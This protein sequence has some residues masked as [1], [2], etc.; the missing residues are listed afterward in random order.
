MSGSS[1]SRLWPFSCR[2]GKSANGEG[3]RI[4]ADVQRSTGTGERS[5][6]NTETR[7]SVVRAWSHG[8][9][10]YLSAGTTCRRR[11]LEAIGNACDRMSRRP[12]GAGSADN[13][14]VCR[15]GG[16]GETATPE[17]MSITRLG[18]P[19]APATIDKII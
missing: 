12:S 8:R 17:Q 11:R 16:C 9:T 6:S 18:R 19:R 10:V 1:P 7:T 13:E 14:R 2:V 3:T 15:G 5:N 4:C